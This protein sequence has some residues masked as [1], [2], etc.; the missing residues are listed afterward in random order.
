[1]EKQ[2]Y[3]H[4]GHKEFSLDRFNP[5]VNCEHFP[6]PTGGLWA[7]NVD[8]TFTWRDWCERENFRECDPE[9]SFTFTLRDH[10]RVLRIADVKQLGDLPKQETWHTIWD[11]LDFEKLMETYDA[12]ELDLSADFELYWRL[13]GWDCDSILIMNPY[14]V[15]VF[16]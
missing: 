14:V 12:I 16:E 3:I 7:S 10:A 13:Y 4:Y 5:I 2:K 6:K 11:T 1:M 9:N 15:E 8:A